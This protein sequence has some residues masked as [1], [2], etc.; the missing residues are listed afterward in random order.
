[1]EPLLVLMLLGGVVFVV[2]GAIQGVR[3]FRRADALQR[4]L[5]AVTKELHELQRTGRGT[6]AD[7]P[8]PPPAAAAAAPPASPAAPV[9][10]IAST[11][12][13]AAPAIEPVMASPTM[14]PAPPPLP[15]PQPKPAP[16]PP[17]LPKPTAAAA[18]ADAPPAPAP[19][20]AP[21]SRP[22]ATPAAPAPA[23]ASAF[24]GVE[25]TLGL[26]WLT[27]IGL[28]MLF[29]GVAFFLKYAYDRDWLGR[30]FGPRLRIAT[31]T[32]AAGVLLLL[33]WR[34][35]KNG[36]AAF[37]QALLGGGQ[38]LLYL[39]IFAAFQPAAMVVDEPLFGPTTAFA[40]MALVTAGGLAAAVRLDAVA[41]A[42]LAV[43]G[44]FA[45][46]VM[47]QTGRDARDLLCAYLLVLDLGVLA[48][49]SY[50]QWRALDLLAFA[51]TAALFAGWWAAFGAAHPQPDATLAWVAIFHLVFAV[52]PVVQH[53]RRRTPVAI[54]RFALALANLAGTLAFLTHTLHLTA[55][56]LLAALCLVAAALYAG[57]GFVTAH[58][59]GGD[60][61]TRDGYLALAAM[62][63]TLGLFF[64]LPGGALGRRGARRG[65]GAAVARL[66]LRAR[67]DADVGDR[68]AR[69]RLRTFVHDLCR[70]RSYSRVSARSGRPRPALRVERLVRRHAA[71]RARPRRVRRAAPAR[72]TPTPA[73]CGWRRCSYRGGAVVPLLPG[74][75]LWDSVR[76]TPTRGARCAHRWR[77][78]C[79]NGGRV[80][81]PAARRDAGPNRACSSPASR[82]RSPRR[83]DLHRLPRLSG[84]LARPVWNAPLRASRP[85][86]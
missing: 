69:R 12:Q 66:S 64:L 39:T 41:M 67:V 55:P 44:G 1:M 47:I 52:L 54:E 70:A 65:G 86:P 2:F 3:A 82:R 19:A 78:R 21:E 30:F 53:W 36:L 29:L 75:V 5:D 40:L 28:A 14:P 50:R 74:E 61:R 48:V 8:V 23:P 9:A 35:L 45:T 38:A 72:S 80:R 85:S 79:C 49:A 25:Q 13:P 16:S 31:A 43:L 42:F 76:R 18:V 10:P 46:P 22:A 71:R 84:R 7:A 26:R 63:L 62:L 27:W 6:R 73:N 37:G 24:A 60:H 32:G 57:L 4:A 59:V 17:P 15:T 68:C 56:K 51:G 81:L 11:P 77:W 34:S 20:P 83:G 58:R 33:G